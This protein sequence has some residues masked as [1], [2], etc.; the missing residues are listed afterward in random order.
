M[1]G[2]LKRRKRWF[3]VLGIARILL[4]DEG[5]HTRYLDDLATFLKKEVK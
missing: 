1:N 3:R 5:Y 4:E 2:K